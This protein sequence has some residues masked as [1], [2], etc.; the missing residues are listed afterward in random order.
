MADGH[1][2]TEHFAYHY[3]AD[4]ALIRGKTQE[5][6]RR[7]RQSLEAAVPLGDLIETSFEVQGVAMAAAGN[8][9]PERALRLAGSVEALWQSLGTWIS[10]AFWDR[11]LERYLGPAREQLGADADAAWA[12]GRALAFDDAVAL[13]LE[14]A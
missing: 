11:L 6:E 7:Y 3:L 12:E 5:A 14:T 10:V 9:D 2:R 8:G 13:A 4:C 1:R